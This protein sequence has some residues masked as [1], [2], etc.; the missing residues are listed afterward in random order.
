MSFQLIFSIF[1][2]VYAASSF[3]VLDTL[4]NEGTGKLPLFDTPADNPH[5]KT[6]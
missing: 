4:T 5:N 3:F 1:F 2:A 6:Q